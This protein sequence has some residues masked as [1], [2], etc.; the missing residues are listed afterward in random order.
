MLGWR[1]E[2]LIGAIFL[3]AMKDSLLRADDEFVRGAL[4]CEADHARRAVDAV[5][6]LDNRPVAL[7]MDDD[8]RIG[9]EGLLAK[10]V[11][12]EDAMVR[13]AEARVRDDLLRGFRWIP[14]RTSSGAARLARAY[15]PRVPQR[16]Q[17]L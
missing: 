3:E 9:M 15:R 5:R 6:K 16:S 1:I 10:D 14:N 17:Y 12:G 2:L 7:R 13:G 8:Q 11:L 4:F